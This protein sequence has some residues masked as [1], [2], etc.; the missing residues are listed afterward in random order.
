MSKRS[1]TS[2][3]K[4]VSQ[5]Q[6]KASMPKT[7][8]RL[9]TSRTGSISKGLVP[10]TPN[11]NEC[12][13]IKRNKCAKGPGCARVTHKGRAYCHQCSVSAGFIHGLV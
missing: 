11:R 9:S 2:P 10:H 1:T 4:K 5:T 8:A 7:T 13:C 12:V 3:F 6:P